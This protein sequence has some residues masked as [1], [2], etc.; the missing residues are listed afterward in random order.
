MAKFNIDGRSK[1]SSIVSE[2][3]LECKSTSRCSDY[4][5]DCEKVH[6]C[7]ETNNSSTHSCSAN[8]LPVAKPM[9]PPP[10]AAN[11]PILRPVSAMTGVPRH[12]ATNSAPAMGTWG[13]SVRHVSDVWRDL[14]QCGLSPLKPRWQVWGVCSEYHAD[15]SYD[16]QLNF[17]KFTKP[18][19]QPCQSWFVTTK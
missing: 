15:Q 19:G 4:L 14:D 17:S 12:V 6:S 16:K 18:G 8:I 11:I 3:I 2:K 13:G 1:V 5:N 7:V 10:T 9:M